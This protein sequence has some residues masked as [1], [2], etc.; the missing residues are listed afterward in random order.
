MLFQMAE[1]AH[2]RLVRHRF[3]PQ[4]NAHKI[5]LHHRVLQRLFH[6]RVGK[7][8]PLL[9]KVHPQHP[10]YSHRWPPITGLL[11]SAAR[12]TRTTSSTASPAP[13]PPGTPP[14]SS[15]CYSA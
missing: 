15:F 12:S 14:A 3:L 10:F 1:L 4:V 8:E 6:H 2:R 5:A 7:V 13:S 9:Q 11:D